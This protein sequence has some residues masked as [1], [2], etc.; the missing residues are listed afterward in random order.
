MGK[1]SVK[2]KKGRK[3]YHWLA[4]VDDIF[5]GEGDDACLV[6]NSDGEEACRVDF[7]PME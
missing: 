4:A 1:K 3:S 6:L 7:S 5:Q 2:G